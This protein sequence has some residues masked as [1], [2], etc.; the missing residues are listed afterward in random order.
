MFY[1]TTL[2][3]KW[4]RIGIKDGAVYGFTTFFF[5]IFPP[6]LGQDFF[7]NKKYDNSLAVNSYLKDFM[8]TSHLSYGF[9]EH[10]GGVEP[11][12]MSFADSRPTD[13]RPMHNMVPI[14]GFEPARRI[15][16]EF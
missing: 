16:K 5:F 3:I 11:P 15:D 9:L 2:N 10:R 12:N 1:L 6:H 8:L 7:L 13:E 4:N 14:S